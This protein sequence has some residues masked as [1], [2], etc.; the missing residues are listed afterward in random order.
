MGGRRDL[1]TSLPPKS[2]P[3]QTFLFFPAFPLAYPV[4]DAMVRNAFLFRFCLLLF[5]SN[6]ITHARPCLPLVDLPTD[7]PTTRRLLQH[8]SESVSETKGKKKPARLQHTISPSSSTA[9]PS[10]SSAHAHA[11]IWINIAYLPFISYPYCP[12]SIHEWP[13]VR[14]EK[15][16]G[17][18]RSSTC[19]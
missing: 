12:R 4:S 7:R 8:V 13:V 19:T 10:S 2:T 17:S 3:E 1:P 14:L 11:R 9:T 16:L 6:G 5:F 18:E 15:V